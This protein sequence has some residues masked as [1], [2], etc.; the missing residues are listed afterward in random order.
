M[1]NSSF[2]RHEKLLGRWVVLLVEVSNLGH[3][4]IL[5]PAIETKDKEFHIHER[6]LGTLT[7]H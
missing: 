4:Y 1:K 3:A 2:S 6:M 7:T 5:I